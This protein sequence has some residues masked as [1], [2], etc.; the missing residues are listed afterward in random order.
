MAL[1]QELIRR[2]IIPHHVFAENMPLVTRSVQ[3]TLDAIDMLTTRVREN[4]GK[5]VAEF[6]AALAGETRIVDAAY[7]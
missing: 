3:D 6:R 1:R 2:G 4:R 5:L 7:P